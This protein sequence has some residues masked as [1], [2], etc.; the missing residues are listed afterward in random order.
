MSFFSSHVHQLNHPVNVL[1][2]SVYETDDIREVKKTF[3]IREDILAD[4]SEKQC[5]LVEV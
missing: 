1:I 2:H 4:G 3:H 5:S